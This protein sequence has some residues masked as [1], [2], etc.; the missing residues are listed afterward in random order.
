MS[1]TY[2]NGFPPYVRAHPEKPD[3]I[4][5]LPRQVRARRDKSGVWEASALLHSLAGYMRVTRKAR[6]QKLAMARMQSVIEQ[7]KRDPEGYYWPRP[8]NTN[9]YFIQGVSGGPVKIGLAQ[10]VNL[11]LHTIQHYSPVILKVLYSVPGVSH[12][13]ERF[14]HTRLAEHRLHGE[15]FESRYAKF[16]IRTILENPDCQFVT[17]STN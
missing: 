4:V 9:L 14:M 15:W 8:G 7:A 1:D 12:E 11:R 13:A 3:E 17:N 2:L 10:D 16:V 6:S 5:Y